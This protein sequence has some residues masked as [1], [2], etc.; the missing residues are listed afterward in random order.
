MDLGSLLF[1]YASQEMLEGGKGGSFD[2]LLMSTT[3]DLTLSWR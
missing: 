3:G 2:W 1:W